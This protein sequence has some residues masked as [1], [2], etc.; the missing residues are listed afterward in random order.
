MR[1]H[2]KCE[3]PVACHKL[4]GSA[5]T[6]DLLSLPPS[7]RK[8]PSRF[9]TI[10]YTQY[11]MHSSLHVMLAWLLVAHLL[12]AST[13]LAAPSPVFA[14]DALDR[15]AIKPAKVT[16][17]VVVPVRKPT[18]TTVKKVVPPKTT[19]KVTTTAAAAAAVA[20]KASATITVAPANK[21]R[22]VNLGG[23]F[24]IE[25]WMKPSLFA[26]ATTAT[27]KSGLVD[28]WTF[29]SAFSNKQQALGMLQAHWSSWITDADF[30]QIKS[31]GLSELRKKRQFWLH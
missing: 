24:I 3:Q 19:A 26:A 2:L 11:K 29:M 17:K 9:S 27:G 14:D 28:Q 20:A 21:I 23:W 22:G 7:S 30:A 5:S 15:R 12:V 18:S 25:Q 1:K 31:L 8:R 16:K 10:S 4:G 13:V 6:I